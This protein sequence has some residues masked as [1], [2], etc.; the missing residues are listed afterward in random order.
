[1]LAQDGHHGSSRAVRHD[2]ERLEKVARL[3]DDAVRI[4]I[5]GVRVGLDPLLGLLPGAGDVVG[6][7]VSGWMVIT[8]AR[9]GASPATLLR[10]LVNLLVDS[11]LGAVP[12]LGDL[13][14]IGFKANRRN[15]GILQEQAADP[16]G[17]RRKSPTLVVGTLAL[18]VGLL[19]GLALFL[20]WVAAQVMGVFLA[21]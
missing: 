10:M 3:M 21:P 4:P 19:I 5:L 12:F 7:V 16:E 8:A 14:D 17:L 15:L 11:L 13:F 1:M 2:L 9:M 6:G 20:A 18:V